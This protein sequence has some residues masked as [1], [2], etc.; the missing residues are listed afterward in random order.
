MNPGH[1][2]PAEVEPKDMPPAPEVDMPELSPEVTEVEGEP[3]DM[4]ALEDLPQEVD[5]KQFGCPRCYFGPKGCSACKRPGYTPRGPRAKAKAKAKA[6]GSSV[7]AKAKAKA[8]ITK[9]AGRPKK[10]GTTVR[11]SS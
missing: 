10:R 3:R 1:D 2:P 4:P 7:A 5:N 8:K 11:K 9:V 6:K